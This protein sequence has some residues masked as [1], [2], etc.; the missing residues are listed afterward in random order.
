MSIEKAVTIGVAANELSKRIAGTDE[1]SVGR[2]TLAT[3][4]GAAMGSVAAGVLVV[5]GVASAPVTVPLAVAAGLC[6]GIA[7][8][9]G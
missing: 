4:A 3:G 1:V 8:L 5:S 9:F 7:S 2:T 6:A